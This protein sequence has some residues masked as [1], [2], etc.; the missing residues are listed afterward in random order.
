MSEVSK[1][2]AAQAKVAAPTQ[3][4]IY[5][6]FGVP[7]L[8]QALYSLQTLRRYN[9]TIPV[10]ILTNVPTDIS[11]PGLEVRFFD[12]PNSANRLY[13]T[14]IFSH[15]PFDQTLYIDADTE[16][17]CDVAL[18][19]GFLNRGDIA[20]RPEGTPMSKTSREP[21]PAAAA[22]MIRCFGEFN[23]GLMFFNRNARVQALFEAW[24]RWQAT[25]GVNRDQRNFLRALL[26]VPE[27]SAWPLPP[28]WNYVRND[29]RSLPRKHQIEKPFVWHYINFG[30]SPRAY[31][32]CLDAARKY[33][34]P[35]ASMKKPA[36]VWRNLAKPFLS[37][38]LRALVQ[39]RFWLFRPFP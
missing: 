18:G 7:Y 12:E 35:A 6:A 26:E 4:V 23:C 14:S 29:F 13:K 39:R 3:G 28:A 1:D 16:V 34:L 38:C 2:T 25:S 9:A 32:G 21:D 31:F 10:V 22:E 30:F 27:L 15:S 5:L 36:Y 17:H 8:L 20:I 24:A 19:F 37:R 33:G 11:E